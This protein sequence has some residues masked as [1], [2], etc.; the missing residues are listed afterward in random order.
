MC[1]IFEG[2][3]HA[4]V[5]PMRQTKTPPPQKLRIHTTLLWQPG[6]D[7]SAGLGVFCVLCSP[8]KKK[9]GRTMGGSVK[10]ILEWKCFCGPLNPIP[11]LCIQLWRRCSRS[12]PIRGQY[13]KNLT[14]GR[15]VWSGLPEFK[16]GY[17]YDRGTMARAGLH[18]Q[19]TN[20][21]SSYEKSGAS[22]TSVQSC[23]E[24]TSYP[25]KLL[26]ILSLSLESM[27]DASNNINVLFS[28]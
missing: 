9:K 19:H 13:N 22:W 6:H 1:L 17:P 20:S 23:C 2:A 12:Q 5:R 7:L 16:E 26:D 4:L 24:N 11:P 27:A 10:H 28:D 3:T 15:G 25:L 18:Y 14:N 8:E 21:A